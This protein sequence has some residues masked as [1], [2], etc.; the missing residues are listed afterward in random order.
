MVVYHEFDIDGNGSIGFVR[1]SMPYCIVAYLDCSRLQPEAVAQTCKWYICV[2]MC[3]S[4]RRASHHQYSFDGLCICMVCVYKEEHT[5][6]SLGWLMYDTGTADAL[7]APP[8]P[9]V[10]QYSVLAGR[11]D[12]PGQSSASHEPEKGVLMPTCTCVCTANY[13][14]FTY[15][16][17]RYGVQVCGVQGDGIMHDGIMHETKCT[18]MC[19]AHPWCRGS[20]QRR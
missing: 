11:A 6:L 4:K 20:G 12:G 9:P 15:A 18:C 5:Y 17:T 7:T 3:T 1:T 16:R 8:I 2:G 10:F 19:H 14:C 13:L